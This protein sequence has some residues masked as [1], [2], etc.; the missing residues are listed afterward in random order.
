MEDDDESGKGRKKESRHCP[1][2]SYPLEQALSPYLRT[3]CGGGATCFS[4]REGLVAM[5]AGVEVR[6]FRDI[7]G[8]HVSSGLTRIPGNSL[9]VSNSC[10]RSNFP[11]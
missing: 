5:A 4:V 2:G 10:H 3:L 11:V 9:L 6:W 8:P 1:D 7:C